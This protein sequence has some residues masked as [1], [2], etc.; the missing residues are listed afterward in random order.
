M[1]HKFGLR[2]E[3]VTAMFAAGLCICLSLGFVACEEPEARKVTVRPVK[4]LVLGSAKD[5]VT[6]EFPGV[7]R[8][9]ENTTL[10]F[11]VSG[12]MQDFKVVAGQTFKK[13][14]VIAKL[15]PR[16]Y[17]TSLDL[18]KSTLT[19]QRATM[20]KMKAGE[21]E[22]NIAK[23]KATLAAAES[24]YYTAKA[25]FERYETLYEKGDI[26]KADYD[27]QKKARDV[28][29][30]NL[31]NA[32]KSLEV[33]QKGARQEDISIQRAQIKGA[34]AQVQSAKDAVE[35]TLLKAPFDGVI[36]QTFVNSFEKVS[37]QQKIL[38]IQDLSYLI[39]DVDIPEDALLTVN[40][41]E[42]NKLVVAFEALPDREF[43][44]EPH[45]MSQQADPATRTYKASMKFAPP[46][47]VRVLPGMSAVVRV[48]FNMKDA[49]QDAGLVV[50]TEAIISVDQ[51]DPYVWVLDPES[52]TVTKSVIGVG[53]LSRGGIV[54]TRGLSIGTEVVIA[55]GHYLKEGQ[56]IKRFDGNYG[57]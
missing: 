2:R 46:E 6:R 43:P 5:T 53:P 4:T 13:G 33:G 25:Q 3:K 28:A 11:R 51:Q 12:V 41:Y 50:P 18:A 54:V 16:D 38:T 35:Y 31:E 27:V 21:R 14:D 42:R 45:E 36:G 29:S 17:K 26:G 7:V 8:A 32:R 23:L 39:V 47:N 9:W 10:S 15:D 40:Q 56:E 52:M 49:P 30:S 34:S 22:E 44:L 24:S 55:G 48:E 20:V 37:A 1:K 19:G 57:D